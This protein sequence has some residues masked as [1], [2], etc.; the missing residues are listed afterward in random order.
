MGTRRI[1]CGALLAAVVV[2]CNGESGPGDGSGGP[3]GA[4]TGRERLA[5]SQSAAS[6][7]D[8]A[9]LTYLLWI[10]DTAETMT[11]VSCEALVAQT[12]SCSGA[13]RA[14]TPGAHTLSLM[15]VSADGTPSER[16]APLSVTVT[17]GGRLTIVGEASMV[18]PGVRGPSGAPPNPVVTVASDLQVHTVAE[19]L[20]EVTDLAATSD[21]RVFVAERRGFVWEWADGSM[22]PTPALV[23]DEVVTDGGSG[24][25]SLTLSPDHDR[26]GLVYAGYTSTTGF[27]IA[28][29][30][31]GAGSLGERAIVFETTPDVAYGTAVIR[32]GPDGRLYIALD[33]EGAPDRAGDL[34]RFSGKVLRLN[35]DGSAPDD[36]A[37]YSPV[38]VPN[39]RQPHGL[40]WTSNTVLWIADAGIGP[41]GGTL[42]MARI[43]SGPRR[44]GAIVARHAMPDGDRPTASLVYGGGRIAT[45]AGD[46]LVALERSGQVLRLQLAK[47]GSGGVIGT[48][49]VLE[50][51]EPVRA[52]TT[53]RDGTLFLA[54]GHR[55]L[56][57]SPAGT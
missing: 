37:G 53:S 5:W 4:I 22:R 50:S 28:R 10:D 9:D 24:L 14:M 40:G 27:R 23:L 25:L 13:L 16:S 42:D 35:P 7:R 29:F 6:P 32:F 44:R 41:A 18:V 46:V 1:S 11:G 33:D 55:L 19:G 52:L 3:P 12:A 34:G 31:S 26:S 30:R 57:V 2:G 56:R 20:E 45:W 17:G 38:L 48:Q 49:V 8:L 36:Q 54:T 43:D 15:A 47:D 39:L 21:G 51:S